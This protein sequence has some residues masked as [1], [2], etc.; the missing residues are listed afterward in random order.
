MPL[1]IS[2][3]N[4]VFLSFCFRFRFPCVNKLTSAS[5][6]LCFKQNMGVTSPVAALFVFSSCIQER[7]VSNRTA[8]RLKIHFVSARRQRMP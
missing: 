2:K 8:K 3:E 6:A 5:F 7:A 4:D 1:P